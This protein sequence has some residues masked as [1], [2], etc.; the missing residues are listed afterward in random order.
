DAPR[1]RRVAALV[2]LLGLAVGCGGTR[3]AA[4]TVRPAA[5]RPA[6]KP[7]RSFRLP[8]PGPAQRILGLPPIAD[9]P[10]PGYVLIADRDNNRILL[11]SPSKQIVWRFPGPRGAGASF[12]GPDDA[13][14]TP[15]FRRI[16]T[17]EEFHDTIAQIDIRA[18]RIV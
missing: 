14:F 1:V 6:A 2:L 7:V 16:V 9:G 8:P 3:H 13:F 17:N 5:K 12:G 18:R 10:V 4:P 15:R 11:V